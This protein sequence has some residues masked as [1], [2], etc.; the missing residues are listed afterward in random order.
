MLP[1]RNSKTVGALMAG[2]TGLFEEYCSP[3]TLEA[4]VSQ[5]A[6]DMLW[7][8]H[9]EA[10]ITGLA[11]SLA[12]GDA[13][14]LFLVGIGSSDFFVEIWL[15]RTLRSGT[16]PTGPK[17]D[18][19]TGHTDVLC[20]PRD[21]FHILELSPFQHHVILVL[22]EWISYVRQ[23][24]YGTCTMCEKR[25]EVFGCSF[26]N[27]HRI[28][29]NITCLFLYNNNMIHI[30]LRQT[31][32]FTKKDLIIQVLKS[33]IIFHQILKILLAI[34]RDLKEFWN[35]FWLYTLS[36]HGRNIIQD[37]ICGRWLNFD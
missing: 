34:L 2:M 33:L 22:W 5:C 29:I 26:H 13:W 16:S 14:D 7:L 27:L 37:D 15:C 4:W 24:W 28:K 36:A 17:D 9:T 25:M 32:L 31:W 6:E 18:N 10:V 11:A 21:D 12:G 20:F 35:I 19:R 23:Q 8:R 3:S 1:L 30:Y